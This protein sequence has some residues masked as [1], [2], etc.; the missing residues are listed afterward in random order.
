[1]GLTVALVDDLTVSL[2][3]DSGFLSAPRAPRPVEGR[4]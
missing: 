1:M 2:V 3:D 4:L